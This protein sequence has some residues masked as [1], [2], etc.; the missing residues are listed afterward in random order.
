MLKSYIA[1]VIQNANLSQ[2]EAYQAME[3]I[4]TGKATPTQIGGYLVG[5]RMKGETVN[6]ITGSA[7]A[8]R[9]AAE[10]IN[11]KVDGPLIDTAGTGGD[12]SHSINISTTTAFVI[13]GAGFPVAKHG[14]RAASSK[15]GS[16]DV[17]EELGINLD[18]TPLQVKQ[19]IEEVGIG[20]MFAPRFHPAMKYAIGPRRELG[21]RT[22]FNLLGPLTNPA[23]ATHQLIGV[24]DPKLTELMAGVLDELGTKGAMV[25]HGSNGIDE[26]TTEGTNKISQ[27]R[28]G[29][30]ET[31]QFEA[32]E[33]DLRSATLED[34][35]GGDPKY[36]AE[37]LRAILNGNDDSPR[38]DVV[39]L[40]AAA[41]LATVE[42]ELEI[43][44]NKARS[45]LDNGAALAKLDNLISYTQ[46]ITAVN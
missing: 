31:Y 42:G 27:L 37:S 20:F 13:A 41:A 14:N 6:E 21:Q 35:R 23:D 11:P 44:L 8:M 30:V 34:L 5:L 45:A 9:A 15:C 43:G 2:D 38:K 12:G 7:A 28:N 46:N 40:N 25:V 18:L 10:Q 4:M 17:L 1:K 39:L 24:Y 26:L 33:L 19:C 22:I 36:N 32:Q 16:A 29:N 3:T